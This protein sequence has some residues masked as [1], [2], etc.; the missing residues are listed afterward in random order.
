MLIAP[1]RTNRSMPPGVFIPQL[2][3]ANVA[4]A[5]KWLCNTFGFSQ[6]LRIGDHRIQLTFGGGSMVAVGGSSPSAP[7]QSVMVR[8]ENVDRHFEHVRKCGAK[9]VLPP[10]NYPFGERQYTVE[11]FAGYRWTFS[12]S[13]SDV[14]PGTWGGIPVDS[15]ENRKRHMPA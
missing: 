9:V 12:E 7:T 6:R 2:A 8:I 4:E 15:S 13:V 14:D 3:Y 10:E 1:M 5:A 11:D